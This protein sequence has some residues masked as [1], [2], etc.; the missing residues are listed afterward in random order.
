MLILKGVLEKKRSF[1]PHPTPTPL[2]YKNSA[3]NRL[4][5]FLPPRSDEILHSIL[6]G[7]VLLGVSYNEGVP[8]G[9]DRHGLQ[10]LGDERRPALQRPARKQG[11]HLSDSGQR[12]G[13]A[14]VGLISFGGGGAHYSVLLN[15]VIMRGEHE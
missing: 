2:T 1:L 5:V 7:P 11:L 13:G 4:I 12:K 9:P 3:D 6:R 15:N 14:Q 10:G 8:H